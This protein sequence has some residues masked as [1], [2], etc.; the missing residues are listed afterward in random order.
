MWG[1]VPRIYVRD[2]HFVIV[3]SVVIQLI[4]ND[5]S[6]SILVPFMFRLILCLCDEMEPLYDVLGM[7][8]ML[9]ITNVSSFLRVTSKVCFPTFTSIV[10]MLLFYFSVSS[11]SRQV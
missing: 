5:F 6:S 9:G 7:T 4:S 2:G 3:T 8:W 1:C 11:Q 10:Y